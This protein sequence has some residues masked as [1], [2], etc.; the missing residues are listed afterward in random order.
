VANLDYTFFNEELEESTLEFAYYPDK[1]G[2]AVYVSDPET[3]AEANRTHIYIALKTVPGYDPAIKSLSHIADEEDPT[4]VMKLDGAA[5]GRIPLTMYPSGETMKKSIIRV[6]GSIGEGRPI[7]REVMFTVMA[8]PY[9]TSATTVSELTT[10]A[11]GQNVTVTIGLPEGL[12]SSLFPI[13]VRI[14][15]ENNCLSTTNPN[16]PVKDDVSTFEEGESSQAGKRT[17]YYI[18][19]IKYSQYYKSTTGQ[20]T[21]TFPCVFQTTKNSGNAPTKIKISDSQGRFNSV[22]KDLKVGSGS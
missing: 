19:T 7:F 18:Y 11:S 20:Y 6:Q 1:N 5:G 16:I 10:D 13:Q 12:G 15:A 2:S 9:F 3:V 4:I 21:Y 22:I 14:E 17:F 8:K